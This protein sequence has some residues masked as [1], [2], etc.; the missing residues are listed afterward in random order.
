MML[1]PGWL[2]ISLGSFTRNFLTPRGPQQN[3]AAALYSSVTH[4]K[5]SAISL[6]PCAEDTCAP[7]AELLTPKTDRERLLYQSSK[8]SRN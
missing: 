7:R 5:L 8:A 2:H 1:S 6:Q 4:L 3:P